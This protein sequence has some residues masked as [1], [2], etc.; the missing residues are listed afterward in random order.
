MH[1][2]RG[3]ADAIDA[4]VARQRFEDAL[5]AGL[6]ALRAAGVPLPRG[7]RRIAARAMFLA[8]R[9]RLSL[10]A[11]GGRRLHLLPAATSPRAIETESLLAATLQAARGCGSTLSGLIGL[12]GTARALGAGAGPRLAPLVAEA[13]EYVASRRGGRRFA[14]ILAE[15]SARLE[16]AHPRTEDRMPSVDD[17]WHA[18][19]SL[20]SVAAAIAES[21]GRAQVSHRGAAASTLLGYARLVAVL[22]GEPV[23]LEPGS[24]DLPQATPAPVPGAGFRASAAG[25]A[26]WQDDYLRL[27]EAVILDRVDVSVVR[28]AS[29]LGRAVMG[30][31]EAACR[32]AALWFV[33]L[34]QADLVRVRGPSW[35]GRR[36]VRRLAARLSGWT[37]AV[38]TPQPHREVSLQA[39]IAALDGD[40][41]AAMRGFSR[42]ID[43]AR[44][45]GAIG[46]AALIAQRGGRYERTLNPSASRLTGEAVALYRQW[47]ARAKADSMAKA[48]SGSANGHAVAR[49]RLDID[50]DP[51]TLISALQAIG[52]EVDGTRV[53]ETLLGLLLEQ[54]GAR[55]GALV[56]AAGSELRVAVQRAESPELFVPEPTAWTDGIGLPDGLLREVLDEKR[57]RVVLDGLGLPEAPRLLRWRGLACVSLI[58]APL[59]SRDTCLGVVYLEDDRSQGAFESGRQRLVEVLCAQGANALVNARLFAEIDASR[60]TLRELNVTLERR[61]DDRTRALERNFEELA[62]LERRVVA[63]AERQRMIRDL[64]DGLGSQ[65]LATQRQLER[66]ELGSGDVLQMIRDCIADMRLV[67]DA[68][69]ADANDLLI[70]W[71]SLRARWVS[72][73][74]SS[75]IDSKWSLHTELESLDIGPDRVLNILRIAQESLSNAI[76]HARAG[77]VRIELRCDGPDIELSIQD[78]GIGCEGREGSGRGL[79][80][81]RRRAS[82][83][84]GRLVVEPCMPGT[85]VVLSCPVSASAV[86]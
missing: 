75:G 39:E 22:T 23:A 41:L 73:L 43:L 33:A 55:Y 86:N 32:P 5:E 47:G 83:L 71:A 64:H 45:C 81:M 79:A 28:R 53:A 6:G 35:W 34:A 68:S 80:N 44:Q 62:R 16:R 84:G 7:S 78:D 67:L 25:A 40:S 15:D 49:A 72:H 24:L 42:A 54:C 56:F 11:E 10:S 65:L 8:L 51:G 3:A 2:D 17:L 20:A 58:C 30:A 21:S 50:V 61:V 31:A 19:A 37:T 69:G 1:A 18:S 57:T 26:R 14:A 46:E 13:G 27:V 12:V 38:G 66:R 4:L 63:D 36:R 52:A 77:T 60:R 29:G 74:R 82:L 9:L 70:A 76:R 48:L 85:R 59:M